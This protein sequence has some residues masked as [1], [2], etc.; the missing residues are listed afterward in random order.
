MK[1]SKDNREDAGK[2]KAFLSIEERWALRRMTQ[3]F[4]DGIVGYK[5]GGEWE[6]TFNTTAERLTLRFQDPFGDRPVSIS[7]K[8]AEALDR[9]Q[10]V[11]EREVTDQY[12]GS[13]Q[14]QSDASAI[15]DALDRNG[16]PGQKPMSRKRS[17]AQ[18]K[19]KVPEIP[20]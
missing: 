5:Q 6:K 9:F 12:P 2:A 15:R 19:G 1:K 17:Q 16:A 3:Q 7:P 18:H 4:D 13:G 8:E 20:F 14:M 10:K 11:Y